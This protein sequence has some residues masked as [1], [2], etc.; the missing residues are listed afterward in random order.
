M[1]APTV[2]MLAALLLVAAPAAAE[3]AQEAALRRLDHGIDAY[4]VGDY[5]RARREF[6]VARSLVPS[7]ANPYRWLG[8]SELK[9]GDCDHARLDFDRF[10][11]LVP[12]DDARI[13]EV[14][15]LRAGCQ[16]PAPSPA[17]ASAAAPSPA[18]ASAAAPSLAAAAPPPREPLVRRWWFWTAVGGSVAIAAT[19][20]TLGV[21]FGGSHDSRLP[22]IICAPS[23]CGATGSP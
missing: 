1:R 22:P 2:T 18:T 14:T 21:V 6:E 17:S 7:K 12:K 19:A 16:P 15:Q 11:A 8:M 9:L 10:V 23:G 3:D 4:R 13:A 5:E 20:V